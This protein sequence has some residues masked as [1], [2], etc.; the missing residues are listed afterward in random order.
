MDK[1][2]FG[3]LIASVREAGRVARGE[4]KASRVHQYS[5]DQVRRL[6]E[7]FKPSQIVR[8][9]HRFKM[10]QAEFADVLLV[11]KA[12]LQSWEQG[13][14]RPEGPAIALIK[15]MSRNPEAVLEALHS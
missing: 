15:V 7:R 12:T 5:A 1:K 2:L 8:V 3:E 11:H 13:R 6:R 9:R 4:A 10:S 14:R